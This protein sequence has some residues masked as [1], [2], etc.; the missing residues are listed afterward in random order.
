M[1]HIIENAIKYRLDKIP[2]IIIGAEKLKDTDLWQFWIKDNGLDLE[3]IYSDKA[4]QLFQRINMRDLPGDGMGLA[5]CRKIIKL[6]GG[7][8]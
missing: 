7:D 2:H 3:E 5:I 1:Q 6:H 8:I 4:F